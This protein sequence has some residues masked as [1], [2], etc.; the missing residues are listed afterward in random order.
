MSFAKFGFLFLALAASGCYEGIVSARAQRDLG[1]DDVSVSPTG[2]GGEYEA[3]GCGGTVDY[4]CLT[5]R[6][7][8]TCVREADSTPAVTPVVA[9]AAPPAPAKTTPKTESD[10]PLRAAASTMKLAASFAQDCDSVPG[11]RGEGTAELTFES[12]GRVSSVV[13]SEPFRGTPVGECVA[14]K[15][16]RASIPAFSGGPKVARKSFE[17]P[18]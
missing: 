3:T 8:S 16:R 12:D 11:P 6:E 14:D 9:Y 13:L 4:A 7:G 15:F 2:P 5:T 18:T 10:F 1:C 17:V